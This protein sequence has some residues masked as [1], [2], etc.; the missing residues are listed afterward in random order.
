ML[1]RRDTLNGIAEGRITLQFRRWPAARAKAGGSQLTPIGKL[2]F[3]SVDRVAGVTDDDARAAGE[4]DAASLLARLDGRS[5]DIYRIR[6]CLAGGDP[7]IAMRGDDG[8]AD[9]EIAALVRNLDR[10]FARDALTA[11]AE[12]PGRRAADLADCFGLETP[13]FKA[14]IRALKAKGLTE[15]LEVGYRISPRGRRVLEWLSRT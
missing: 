1:F 4:A 14:R 13:R 8:L 6:L 9:D 12:N 11:I 3:E 2:F 15:S 10:G 7:R 5:G